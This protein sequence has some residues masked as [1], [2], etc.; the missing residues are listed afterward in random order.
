M[1]KN[2]IL[3]KNILFGE[4]AT[5][6]IDDAVST[7]LQVAKT[8]YG[9][10]AG[11]VLLEQNWPIGNAKLSRDGVTNLRKIALRDRTKNMA[12]KTVIQASEKNNASVGDGT[13]AAAMLACYFYREARKLV[14]S[15]HNQME[16]ARMIEESAQKAIE[17]I[18]SISQSLEPEDL[19]NVAR[20]SSGD[21]EIAKLLA[22]TVKEVGSEGGITVEEHSGIGVVAEVID[23]FYMRKGYTDVRLIQD[24]G[25]LSSDFHEVP[26]L[27]LDKLITSGREMATI[28]DKI[29]GNGHRELLILGDVAQEALETLVNQRAKNIMVPTLAAIPATAGMRSIVLDDIAL[30][31]GGTVYQSGHTANSFTLD[32]LGVAERALV[33]ELSTTIVGGAGDEDIIKTRVDELEKQ[34]EA[35]HHPITMNVLKDRIARLKGKVGVIKVGA[36]TDIDREELRLRVDDAVCALQ[37][38]RRGGTVPG[39]GTALARVKGTRFDHV[40]Q[41]LF[42][43]LM[44]NAGERGELKLDKLLEQTCRVWL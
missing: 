11:N 27:L 30:L 20:I 32:F 36:P 21:D 43:D 16:I 2:D 24:G 42:L 1:M 37:A 44:D 17:Y 23:G 28:L 3:P 33:D 18:D 34:L 15:G 41:Q 9:P 6:K 13:T 35:E 29:R 31:T 26:V 5:E 4:K 40:F 12:A 10:K 39:G 8:A 7:V 25:T 14:A 19:L 22:E 38:A